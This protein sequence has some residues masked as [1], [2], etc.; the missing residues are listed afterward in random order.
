MADNERFSGA[1]YTGVVGG[2]RRVPA[3]RYT[4]LLFARR[5]LV[6]MPNQIYRNNKPGVN[7][8][9]LSNEKEIDDIIMWVL[10][11]Q[12]CPSAMC[13]DRRILRTPL[14]NKHM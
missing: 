5:S 7:Q 4:A 14:S 13:S 8:D 6:R 2:S 10:A 12:K 1:R 3:R 11:N 9:R